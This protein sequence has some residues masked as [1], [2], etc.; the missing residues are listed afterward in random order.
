MLLAQGGRLDGTM[1]RRRL[2]RLLVPYLV[3]SAVAQ[4]TG[5]SGA[6]SAGRVA[7]QIATGA[8]L[9]IYYYVFLLV[10]CLLL[11]W[12]VER[13]P[14]PAAEVVLA[15]LCG[16]A[17]LT[18]ALATGDES[19][20]WF[21]RNPL[22]FYGYFLAGIVAWRHRSTLGRLATGAPARAAAVACVLAIAAYF[23]VGPRFFYTSPAGG[24][25]KAVYTSGVVGLIGLVAWRREPPAAVRFLS[26]S[27]Y[28]IY[29]Y[30]FF[31]ERLVG[32]FLVFWPAAPRIA[33]IVGA[34]L[35]GATLVCLVGLALFPTRARLLL[36]V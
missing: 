14:G 35:V 27:S 30:H 12:V 7:F 1:L 5:L 9:F 32:R 17:I 8:S 11:T 23:V 4:V 13:F 29:L 15:A 21:L 33:T 10:V 6:G 20:F 16:W 18:T 24:I 28:A 22:H 19:V 25:L 2:R 26:R 31:F 36:G 3:A 34:G